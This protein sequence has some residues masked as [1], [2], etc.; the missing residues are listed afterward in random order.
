M[1]PCPKCRLTRKVFTRVPKR[2]VY[3]SIF[4]HTDHTFYLGGLLGHASIRRAVHRNPSR[5]RHHRLGRLAA[6]LAGFAHLLID[7]GGLRLAFWLALA[8]CNG[9]AVA[10]PVRLPNKAELLLV[11]VQVGMTLG[12]PCVNVCVVCVL[13]AFYTQDNNSG[14]HARCVVS[15]TNERVGLFRLCFCW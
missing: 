4:S 11:Q 12:Q 13:V 9:A 6:L 3:L 15:C 10:K 8:A 7:G 1:R 14:G 2:D 5:D